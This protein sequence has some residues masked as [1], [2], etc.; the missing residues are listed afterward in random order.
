MQDGIHQ[1]NVGKIGKIIIWGNCRRWHQQGKISY[2]GAVDDGSEKGNVGKVGKIGKIS[3][4]G[5][6]G[7][8]SEKGNVGKIG[9]ISNFGEL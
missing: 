8:G 5:A 6:V 4:F 2:F 9:K 3:N 1:G 7:D